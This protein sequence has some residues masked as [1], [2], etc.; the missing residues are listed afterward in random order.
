MFMLKVLVKSKTGGF[1]AYFFLSVVMAFIGDKYLPS[2]ALTNHVSPFS[3]LLFL[4]T[5]LVYSALIFA[6]YFAIRHAIQFAYDDLTST[7]KNLR[8]QEK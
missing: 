4:F 7:A 3:W 8:N 5:G 2:G 6:V 1:L